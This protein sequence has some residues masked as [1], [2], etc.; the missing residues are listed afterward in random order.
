MII[1]AD[2]HIAPTGGDFAVEKH[3]A[4]MERAGIDKTLVWLKPDYNGVEIEGHNRYI[5][6]ATRK[7]PDR[8][9]GFGWADPTVSVEHALKMVRV[10]TEEYGFYGVK[11]NGAQN[12][13][14][15]DDP[16]IALPVAEAIAKTGKALAFHIGPDAYERTHPLRARKIARMFPETPIMMV[17]M[18][19]T[20]PMMNRVVVEVA[21]ECPNMHLIGSATTYK[22]VLDAIKALGAERVLFGTDAPFQWP[23]VVKAMYDAALDGVVSEKEKTLVMG[24]NLVQL[25]GV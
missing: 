17:H 14:F 25:L 12:C 5:Y 18:G 3:L 7:Y 8:L 19:M 11:M 20:D 1:D 10:C 24:G 6:D 4:R 13:Y 16:E 9:I 22:A 21:K 23:H 15:I 2:T